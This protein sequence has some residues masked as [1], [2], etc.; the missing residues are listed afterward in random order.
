[1]KQELN[2]RGLTPAEAQEALDKARQY[3]NLALPDLETRLAEVQK[4]MKEMHIE[5]I[6]EDRDFAW[7]SIEAIKRYHPE[8]LQKTQ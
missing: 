2:A 4:A 7:E 3:K 6:Q 8:L 1:M 5:Y